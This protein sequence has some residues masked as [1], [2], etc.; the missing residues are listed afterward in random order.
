MNAR[1]PQTEIEPDEEEAPH[2][3]SGPLPAA[4]AVAW[5]IAAML[6]L[7]MA[8]NCA[9]AWE[10]QESVFQQIALAGR[11]LIWMMLAYGLARAFDGATRP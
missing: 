9:L 2:P 3:L 4:R 6:M 10:N 8:F 11:T 1:V 7:V 5:L